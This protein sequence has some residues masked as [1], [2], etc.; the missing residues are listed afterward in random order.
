MYLASSMQTKQPEL[1][2]PTALMLY[3][4]LKAK[5]MILHNK[6]GPIKHTLCCG[7]DPGGRSLEMVR[8]T[9]EVRFFLAWLK[10]L[11]GKD[12]MAKA[13]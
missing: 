1:I 12:G 3:E 5:E 6:C 11:S 4:N 8:Q 10:L 9:A 13:I 2:R 7:A